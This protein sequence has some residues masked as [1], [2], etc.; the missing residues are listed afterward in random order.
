MPH[1]ITYYMVVHGTRT[2]PFAWQLRIL[3]AHYLQAAMV[4]EVM[5]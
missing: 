3:K 4:E 2:C 1:Y 5:G